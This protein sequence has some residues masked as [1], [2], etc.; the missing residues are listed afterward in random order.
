MSLEAFGLGAFA[1]ELASKA[2][3]IEGEAREGLLDGADV[4][5]R[6]ARDR[7]RRLTGET[8]DSI[9][10]EPASEGVGAEWGPTTRQGFYLEVGTSTMGP[11]PY[12][13]PSLEAAADVAT[14]Q[15]GRTAEEL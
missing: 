10:A 9:A 6:V 1:A 2:G 7:V 3:R 14:E 15:L 8:A 5:V 13:E 4:G 12:L 11:F